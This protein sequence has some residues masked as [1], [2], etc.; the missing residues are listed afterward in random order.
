MEAVGIDVHLT[1]Q[2]AG[3]EFSPHIE[4]EV[5]WNGLILLE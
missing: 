1:A 5:V 3:L 4:K 2:G